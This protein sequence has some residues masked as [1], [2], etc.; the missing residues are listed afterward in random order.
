M[1]F[2]TKDKFQREILN[3]YGERGRSLPWRSQPLPYYIWISEIMLQQTRVE[4]VIEYFNRFVKNFPTIEALA[5]A[6]IEEVLKS[7]EGLGY[8]SR[9]RNIHKTANILVA[10]YQGQLPR[11]YQELLQLPGIGPYTAGAISSIAFGKSETAIDGNFIR[12]GS[13]LMAYEGSTKNT[14]GKKII[15]E[16][17]RFLLPEQAPGHFNQGIMDLGATICLPNGMPLCEECPVAFCCKAHQYGRELDFPKKEVKKKRRMEKKTLFLM[18]EN[19]YIALEQR[20]NKGLL[21]GLWQFPMVNGHL[22]LEEGRKWLEKQELPALRIEKSIE[23]K[24]I[25]SHVEWD[26]ISYLVRLE[27][28]LVMDHEGRSF[29][30]K[31][32]KELEKLTL[33]TAF[34]PFREVVLNGKL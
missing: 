7:W 9:A 23:Y 21:A 16:F 3:F 4:T 33:P 14:A 34:R 27:P 1:D 32:E 10:D 13:R 15:D 11:K 20:K 25:F 18:R 30:W 8:Y 17:W 28:W 19:D 5:R 26:M 12:V 6:P 22:S 24:H 29:S 31:Q 2:I